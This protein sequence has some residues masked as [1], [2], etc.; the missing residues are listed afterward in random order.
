MSMQDK[1]NAKF[2]DVPV[3]ASFDFPTTGFYNC[4]KTGAR[5]YT[6]VSGGVRYPATVGTINAS[7]RWNGAL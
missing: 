2:R 4:I 1:E 6:Y 5:S 3:G 7:V